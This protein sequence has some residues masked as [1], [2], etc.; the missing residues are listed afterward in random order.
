MF[1][2]SEHTLL[3]Y[4]RALRLIN[5]NEQQ[6]AGAGI[7]SLS[8]EENLLPPFYDTLR[9]LEMGN[10]TFASLALTSTWCVF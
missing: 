4:L 2:Y 8:D 1:L 10:S 7:R 6:C 3:N 9:I 5:G